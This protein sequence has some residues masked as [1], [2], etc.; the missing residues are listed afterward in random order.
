MESEKPN[1]QLIQSI[2][3]DEHNL[4]SIK[5]HPK[6]GNFIL[7][8]STNGTCKLWDIS[9]ATSPI[10]IYTVLMH[11]KSLNKNILLNRDIV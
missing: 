2:K 6:E 1:F 4:T 11:I 8:A 9:K 5:F 7:S 10:T 3:A